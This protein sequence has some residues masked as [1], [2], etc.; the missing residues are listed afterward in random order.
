MTCVNYEIVDAV[1]IA[2]G[3]CVSLFGICGNI[4]AFLGFRKQTKKKSTSFLFQALALADTLVI[5][6]LFTFDVS[7]YFYYK[8]TF[9]YTQFSVDALVLFDCFGEISILLTNGITILLTVTRL[10]AVCFPLYASTICSIRRV[11][12]YL[13]AT[14]IAAIGCFLPFTFAFLLNIEKLTGPIYDVIF[15]PLVFS[16]FPLLIITTMTIIIMVRLKVLNNRRINM[17]A[18]HRRKNKSTRVLITVNIVFVV[19]SL[20]WPLFNVLKYAGLSC[21]GSVVSYTV[22]FFHIVNSSVNFL[23]Y[24]MLSKQYRDVVIQNCRCSCSRTRPDGASIN[25]TAN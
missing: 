22:P 6:T 11:R 5:F 25:I 21:I 16:A 20:P 23:I 1:L 19:C 12:C 7:L 17:T 9:A 8:D 24:T 18:A 15:R 4:V 3:A 13:V 14:I 10:I 2:L